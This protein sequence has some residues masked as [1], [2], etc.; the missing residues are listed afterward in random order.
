MAEVKAKMSRLR[1]APRKVR[2]VAELIKGMDYEPAKELLDNT[3]KRAA[4]HLMRL[5][6]S[7]AANGYNNFNLV[8]ENLYVKKITIDEGMKL[9]RAKAKGFGMVMWIEKKTSHINLVLDERVAGMRRKE[10]KKAEE[11][12]KAEETKEVKETKEE[13]KQVKQPE[14]QKEIGR[15]GFLGNLKK[16]MFRRKAI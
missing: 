15:K 14:V 10:E 5:L 2:A 12:K 3:P 7:A 13:E 16:K 9:K 1:I 4:R 8:K 11:P 6:D